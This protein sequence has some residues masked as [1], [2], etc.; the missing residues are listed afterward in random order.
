MIFVTVGNYLAFPRLVGAVDDLKA[1]GI[2]ADDVVMQ[3]GRS[4]FTSSHCQTARFLSPDD[5]YRNLNAASVVISH[6][7]GG[8][9]I[10]A[11]R[12][13]KTPVVMPRQ[14]RH[15]EHVDDHQVELARAMAAENR[16]ILALETSDLPAAI[17]AAQTRGI[18]RPNGASRRMIDLVS[19]AIDE[20][21]NRRGEGAN[22]HGY[23]RN[24]RLSR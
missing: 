23:P 19:R 4:D 14:R 2:I 24:Q 12:A 22:C 20:L 15:G 16:V 13:G 9:L 6:G 8:S 18:T 1:R 7:G 17:E 3:V 5:F 10:D 11:M 21:I